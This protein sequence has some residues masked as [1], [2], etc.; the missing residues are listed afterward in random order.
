MKLERKGASYHVNGQVI[1]CNAL[2]TLCEEFYGKEG[3]RKIVSTLDRNGSADVKTVSR[4]LATNYSEELDA[5]N[6]K[7][8]A[9]ER[10]I[11]RQAIEK[12]Y[13]SA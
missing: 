5:A 4:E 12:F 7:I 9:L 10:W 11:A 1:G 2:A 6:K 3:W 13:R 8:T